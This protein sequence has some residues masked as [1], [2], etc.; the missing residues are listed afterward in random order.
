MRTPVSSRSTGPKS[1]KK[2]SSHKTPP[3]A[4]LQAVGSN[5]LTE[6]SGS[7]ALQQLAHPAPEMPDPPD[8]DCPPAVYRR[9][10]PHQ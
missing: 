2:V 6:H 4:K 1:S 7:T 9:E 8:Q 3:Y 5:D 10:I